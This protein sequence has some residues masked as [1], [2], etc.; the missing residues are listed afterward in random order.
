MLQEVIMNGRQE[1]I[2][3][4]TGNR[5]KSFYFSCKRFMDVVLATLAL[6]L[7]MP[8]ML[9]IAF[10]IKVD[11]PGPIFFI[12]E[13]AGVRRRFEGG[14]TIWEIRNFP[15]YKFRS[16]TQDADP[17]IH[18]AYIKAFVKGRIKM[19][20]TTRPKFKLTNDPR[21]TRVG[22][23]LR[24]TSLDELP[25]LLNVLKGEM[26]LVGPRPVPLYEVAEYQAWH[27]E[28]L[29]TLSGISG[30]WQVKGRC[31]VSFEDMISLDIEYIRSQS[32]WLDLKILLLTIPAILSGQ[33]AE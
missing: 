6:L 22:R 16:M 33:G 23:I 12:Q 5:D 24:K 14:Q 4:S 9:L 17:S 1:I 29:A 31:Q 25:Q 21:V 26:S 32:L 15:F 2:V 10:L 30:L 11:S 13:R 20:G 18:Q 19:S 8:L 27:C 28:R 7:L 3:S